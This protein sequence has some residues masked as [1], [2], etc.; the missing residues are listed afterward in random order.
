M[1]VC[2]FYRL[3]RDVMQLKKPSDR[4]LNIKIKPN[5]TSENNK[6]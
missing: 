2:V 3:T 4:L 5:Q 6:N 1:C